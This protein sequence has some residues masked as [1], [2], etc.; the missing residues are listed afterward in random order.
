MLRRD[1]D[2]KDYDECT[3]ACWIPLASRRAG[4]QITAVH[5]NRCYRTLPDRERPMVYDCLEVTEGGELT[6]PTW[7]ETIVGFGNA[8]IAG[9][10]R[11]VLAIGSV[12][13]K[14]MM[15]LASDDWLSSGRLVVLAAG[16]SPIS[17]RGISLVDAPID[18]WPT[19]M[20]LV[21]PWYMLL[22]THAD[23][24]TTDVH[25]FDANAHEA[26]HVNVPFLA[27]QPAVDGTIG[28]VYISGDGLAAVDNGV[29]AWEVLSREPSWATSYQ[30]GTLAVTSGKN[31]T[32]LR[33]D[34]M[35][36]VVL[37]TKDG[38]TIQTPPA[39]AADGSVWFATDNAIHVAR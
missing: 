27:R 34:G 2:D 26:W 13:E 5:A 28:R 25:A 23:T 38:L 22:E 17:H 35:Q 20:S 19:F 24:G 8:L 31:L 10:G 18:F 33:R 1:E 37:S 30:D 4:D 9:D 32:I 29:I 15:R 39:I 7:R 6:G 12:P 21:E 16:G 3:Y 36:A 14:S 11:V